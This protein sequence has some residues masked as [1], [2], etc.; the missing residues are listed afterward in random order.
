MP[1]EKD[2]KKLGMVDWYDP[3]QLLSTAGKTAIS[4]TIG[5]YADPRTGTAGRALHRG[6]R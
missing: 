2:N 3:R 5:E 6:A 4:E 1:R